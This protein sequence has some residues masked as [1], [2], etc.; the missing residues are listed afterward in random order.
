MPC[1]DN[2]NYTLNVTNMATQMNT[3][4]SYIP[5]TYISVY[6]YLGNS[7]NHQELFAAVL[8]HGHDVH[9]KFYAVSF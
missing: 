7:T 6:I 8:L 1:N 3:A 2:Y 4:T 5:S 9:F